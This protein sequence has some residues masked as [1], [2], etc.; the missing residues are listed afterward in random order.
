MK[1]IILIIITSLFN[2]TIWAQ[3]ILKKSTKFL[4]GYEVF[5]EEFNLK[6][7]QIFTKTETDYSDLK[8]HYNPS[9]EA[10]VYDSLDKLKYKIFAHSMFGYII[11]IPEYDKNLNPIREF[12]IAS[13]YYNGEE[14]TESQ[15][16]F[17]SSIDNFN[18]IWNNPMT[19]RIIKKGK[20]YL[21]SI[22]KYNKDDITDEIQF[23]KNGDTLNKITYLNTECCEKTI[24]HRK[25]IK[26][27]HI[28]KYDIYKKLIAEIRVDSN[29][30]YA[31]VG[32][33]TSENVILKYN[34]DGLIVE[35]INSKIIVKDENT[36][37]KQVFL[38]NDSKQLVEERMY[39]FDNAPLRI[40][41][42]EY[43]D[44]LI[45]AEKE[46]YITYIEGKAKEKNYI[47]KYKHEY[48][49]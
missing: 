1:I 13:G 49:P 12:I 3:K 27:E 32:Q 28:K 6:G 38:Y 21:N 8:N 42:Y 44:S 15:F 36:W 22:K 2:N 26:I 7:K 11:A 47:F 34:Q 5:V 10:F 46:K 17:L 4:D 43:E 24:Y 35:K 14:N 37:S 30:H 41:T 29:S 25:N 48:Y 40:K 39:N 9:I 33:D 19:Q 16:R 18:D 31:I 45:A 23:Y 20:P